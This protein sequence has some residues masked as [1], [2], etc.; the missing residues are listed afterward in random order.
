MGLRR[1]AAIWEEV[2][3]TEP[4]G[5]DD[6]FFALGGGSLEA[7][8]ILEAVARTFGR[9]LPPTALSAASTC[10][11]LADATRVES[12]AGFTSLILMARGEGPPLFLFPGAGGSVHCF[13]GVVRAAELGRPVYG[14]QL[15]TAGDGDEPPGSVE[16][17]AG[18]CLV[19]MLEAQPHD[20]YHLAGY[21]FGGRVAFEVA[22]R[23]A[24]A[25]REVAFLGLV[26]TYGPG[27]PR[28]KPLPVHV[29]DHLRTLARLGWSGRLGYLRGMLA[30][31]RARVVLPSR[32]R[33]HLPWSRPVIV[34]DYIR[35]DFEYHRALSSRYE[36]RAYSGRLTLFRAEVE[37]SL[38]G[39]DFGDPY[40]GWGTLAALGVAV[41]P[42]PG[43][44]L[45]LFDEPHARSL[46]WALR[47]N[48][49]G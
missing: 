9:R 34:P 45:N 41:V 1:M 40:L 3:G 43:D 33:G 4:V 49:V 12:G 35:D 29:A 2:L 36:P 20:P 11:A 18:R 13:E 14:V 32:A 22:R 15:P 21:S 10:R 5:P 25:G 27:Y 24:D 42:V 17:L 37:P 48:L 30:R 7:I 26:D 46:A 19:A 44:H 23:L 38:A 8:A 31:A 16:A 28:R 6:D 47:S 39:S